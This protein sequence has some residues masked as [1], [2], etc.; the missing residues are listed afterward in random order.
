MT[1]VVELLLVLLIMELVV[2][3]VVAAIFCLGRFVI[4]VVKIILKEGGISVLTSVY[5]CDSNERLRKGPFF[6]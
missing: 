3:M 1:T 5:V 2:L 4:V 6:F